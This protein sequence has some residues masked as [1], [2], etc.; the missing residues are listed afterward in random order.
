[1][2]QKRPADRELRERLGEL[3]N[4]RR[5]FGYRRLFVLLRQ[6][7]ERS[8]KNRI[9]RLYR[10]EGLTVRKRR[11]R[12]RAVERGRRSLSRRSERALIFG[13]RA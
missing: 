1:M 11:G 3:A 8:G 5:R 10:E 9:Y 6:E 7:G 2:R 12:R 13:L 4:A